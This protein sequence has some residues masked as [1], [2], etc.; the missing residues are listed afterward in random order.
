MAKFYIKGSSVYVSGTLD[1][2]VVSLWF[3]EGLIEKQV[4]ARTLFVGPISNI[5]R[6]LALAPQ[7]K[8]EAILEA[9]QKELERAV[10]TEG[11]IRYGV[12]ENDP[13]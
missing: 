9:A 4:R 1:E 2:P 5:H 3:N 8:N 6:M 10:A 13:E 11:F 12:A 7:I